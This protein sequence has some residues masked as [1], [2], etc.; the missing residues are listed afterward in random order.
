[1][2]LEILCGE[3]QSGE[4]GV[5]SRRLLTFLR[6]QEWG[7]SGREVQFV[8]DHGWV[9][10]KILAL[11]LFAN[12]KYIKTINFAL[13]NESVLRG[14]KHLLSLDTFL[15]QFSAGQQNV[16]GFGVCCE[17]R[18]P[19][20]SLSSCPGASCGEKPQ[21]TL[22]T[23]PDPMEPQKP[24]RKDRKQCVLSSLLSLVYRRCFV[25]IFQQ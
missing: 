21:S 6:F 25:P 9:Q 24:A 17:I 5:P 14:C 1:M 12:V 15:H 16:I 23:H 7:L 8:S 18:L 13:K 19:S 4:R 22:K 3:L 10:T 11:T 20:A 2:Y